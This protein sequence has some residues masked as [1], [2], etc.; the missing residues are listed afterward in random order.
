MCNILHSFLL[1]V[2]LLLALAQAPA[3]AQSAT[4][5]VDWSA[6]IMAPAGSPSGGATVL[7]VSGHIAS[8]WHV[9]ALK[10]LGVGPT[11]LHIEVTDNPVAA[12][13]GTPVGPEPLRAPDQGFGFATFSYSD[14]VDIRLPLRLKAGTTDAQSAIPVTVRFQVCSDREC[15]PPTTVRL[16][17][18]IDAGGTR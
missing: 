7:T 12:P 8:G 10:Q 17:A 1:S 6:A 11:P 3:Y 5:L 14:R 16:T 9:Y 13:D 15:R 2:A 4:S 18:H